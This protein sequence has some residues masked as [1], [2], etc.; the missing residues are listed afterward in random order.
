MNSASAGLQVAT[1]LHRLSALNAAYHG[2]AMAPA[3][4]TGRGG[5]GFWGWAPISAEL[6]LHVAA[7][8]RLLALAGQRCFAK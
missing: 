2:L 4:T 3:A 8:Q 6:P 1:E 7:A 5:L